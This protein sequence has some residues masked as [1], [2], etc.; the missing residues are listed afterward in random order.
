MLVFFC[1]SKKKYLKLQSKTK[2]KNGHRTTI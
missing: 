1:A 2:R